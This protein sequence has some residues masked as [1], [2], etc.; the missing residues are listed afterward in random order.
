M[1]H[2]TIND[3]V[4][5]HLQRPQRHAGW[6]SWKWFSTKPATPFENHEK[7]KNGKLVKSI[8]NA[9][10]YKQLRTSLPEFTQKQYSKDLSRY[11]SRNFLL[12]YI[13]YL[14]R[15]G[16]ENGN[17]A[18]LRQFLRMFRALFIDL[19]DK[20]RGKGIDN[21]VLPVYTEKHLTDRQKIGRRNSISALVSQTLDK[22]C[23][24]LGIDEKMT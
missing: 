18:G 15:R 8:G 19:L 24:I 9:G 10:M 6:S 4:F 7:F 12:E 22:A 2:K 11:Y 23:E 3:Y 5:H 17:R 14:E 13:I 20:Y 1:S 21:Y 16:I